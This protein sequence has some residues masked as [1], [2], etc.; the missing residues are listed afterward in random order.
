M[1]TGPMRTTREVQK[2]QETRSPKFFHQQNRM[3][4]AKKK[5]KGPWHQNTNTITLGTTNKHQRRICTHSIS[6]LEPPSDAAGWSLGVG[7]PRPGW[8]SGARVS[9]VRSHDMAAAGGGGP[10]MGTARGAPAAEGVRAGPDRG[11]VAGRGRELRDGRHG[12]PKDIK[13]EGGTPALKILLMF[14]TVLANIGLFATVCRASSG[15]P[16]DPFPVSLLLSVLPWF[17]GW[18]PGWRGSVPGGPRSDPPGL[19][20]SAFGD[21]SSEKRSCTETAR[22][23]LSGGEGTVAGGA[24]AAAAAGPAGARCRCRPSRSACSSL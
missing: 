9:A 4:L 11:C 14:C 20:R 18:D 22:S 21:S 16:T 5:E 15:Y 12:E 10:D 13:G 3:R 8:G 19:G 6:G 17:R 23:G 24:P 2:M 7:R 1:G